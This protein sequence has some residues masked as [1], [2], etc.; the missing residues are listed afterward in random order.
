M[1][2]DLGLREKSSND[3]VVS[4]LAVRRSIGILGLFLPVSLIVYG[5]FSPDGILDSMSAY[6]Y[7]P[8]R[9]VFVGTLCALAVFLWTY[10]GYRPQPGEWLSDRVVARVASLGAAGIALLPTAPMPIFDAEAAPVVEDMPLTCTI[11]QCV[12]GDLAAS[13]IHFLSAAAFFGAMAVFLLFMFTKGGADSAGKRAANRIYR[14]CGL[15]IVVALALIGVLQF[16]GLRESLGTLRPVFWLEV[17]AS[18]AIAVGWMTKGDS[19]QPL[20]KALAG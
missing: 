4:F 8:M 6:Y 12:L 9:E 18:V 20:Q 5:L 11:S 7:S 2:E 1:A 15:V 19:M 14:A 13:M 16:T 10:E 17:A 3:L